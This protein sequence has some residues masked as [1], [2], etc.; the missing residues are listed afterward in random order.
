MI[1]ENARPDRTRRNFRPPLRIVRNESKT[2]R[3]ILMGSW[4]RDIRIS[5]LS[6]VVFVE[7]KRMQP[8]NNKHLDL[9]LLF[10]PQNTTSDPFYP[11]ITESVAL[12]GIHLK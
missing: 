5:S 12:V 11:D 6:L 10:L 2:A 3:I 1:Y 8:R 9:A 4:K 7:E